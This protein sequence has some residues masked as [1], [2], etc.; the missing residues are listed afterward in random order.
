M[1]EAKKKKKKVKKGDT[2][3]ATCSAPGAVEIQA[4]VLAVA[5]SAAAALS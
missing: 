5:Y 2:A 4:L 1:K 3:F